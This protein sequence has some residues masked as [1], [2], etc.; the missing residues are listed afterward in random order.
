MKKASQYQRIFFFEEGIRLGGIG[1]HFLNALNQYGFQGSYTLTAIDH[2]IPQAS[3]ESS[4]K[5]LHL[6][7][8]G[9]IKTIVEQIN[10]V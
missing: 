10:E 5:Q 9:M 6:D 4:L 1:E 7:R 8:D 3:V 2:F